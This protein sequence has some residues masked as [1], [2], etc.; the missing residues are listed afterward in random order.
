MLI[1]LR[2][3]SICVNLFVGDPSSNGCFVTIPGRMEIER[4]QRCRVL[5][6][7]ILA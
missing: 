4:G 2:L 3:V 6:H 5:T 7:E 1:E